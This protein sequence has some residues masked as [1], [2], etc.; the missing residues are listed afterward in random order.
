[1]TNKQIIGILY[2][3]SELLEQKKENTF[4][5]RAYRKLAGFLESF[6]KELA[7]IYKEKGKAGLV[8]IPN[9]GDGI[10]KKIV[11]LLDTGKLTYINELKKGLPENQ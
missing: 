11:E 7:D 1:M 8:E 2:E 9:I 5:I 3:I 4:K 10:A 6:D